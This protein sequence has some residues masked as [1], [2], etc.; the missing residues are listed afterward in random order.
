[1]YSYS[2]KWS[3]ERAHLN[4]V[5]VFLPSFFLALSEEDTSVWMLRTSLSQR[6]FT[7]MF[8]LAQ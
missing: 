3:M 8:V 5:P 7:V 4:L 1:M 2:G 6:K